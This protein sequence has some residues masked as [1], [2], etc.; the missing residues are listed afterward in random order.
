MIEVISEGSY[1]GYG[2]SSGHNDA[3]EALAE[4][5]SHN[6]VKFEASDVLMYSGCSSALENCITVLSCAE[7][8]H[9]ILIPRPGFAIYRTLAE[10]I[11]V[12]IKYYNLLVS[13]VFCVWKNFAVIW[14]FFFFQPHKKFQ[15][16]LFDLEAQIDPKTA[17]IVV[18]NPSNP[19]GSVYTAQHLRDTLAIASKHKIPVIADEIYERLVFPGREFVSMA[20]LDT[21]VPLLICGGLSKRFLI[22]GLWFTLMKIYR[23]FFLYSV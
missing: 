3:K 23:G 2:P 21:D 15:I 7:E 5:M 13:C 4:Y 8:G 19:C 9:N 20:A 16:D 6:G 17:A 10:S 22:P 14:I 1:N 18:N 11:G 12:K